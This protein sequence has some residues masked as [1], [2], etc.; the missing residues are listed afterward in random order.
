MRTLLYSIAFFCFSFLISCKSE[1]KPEKAIKIETKAAVISKKYHTT[2]YVTGKFDPVS[3]SDFVLISDKLADRTGMYMRKEA[4]ESFVKMHKAAANDG[5]SLVIRSATR[6]FTY[7][8]GIWER[9]WNGDRILSDGTNAAKDIKDDVK[10]SLKILEYSSMPGSSRHHWGTDID[11]N[12]FN[13]SYFESGEGLKVYNW[14]KANASK[15]GYCQVYCEKGHLRSSG[16][17]EEKWHYSYMPES[18]GIL[19]YAKENLNLSHL[20]GFKGDHTA[21]AVGII[22]K[23]I[24]GINSSCKH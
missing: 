2:D 14:L 9:K 4:Y 16:Y 13:N 20:K 1:N 11:L 12:S 23:Y 10:R 24:L 3:E 8:R 7:Q 18:E 22:E 19:A 21:A 15:Y 6:N 5:V 17:N